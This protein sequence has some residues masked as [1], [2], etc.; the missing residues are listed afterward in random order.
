M[1]LAI[2]LEMIAI[3]GALDSCKLGSNDWMVKNT[4]VTLVAKASAHICA[5]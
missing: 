3:F 5:G 2:W 4:P 1:S